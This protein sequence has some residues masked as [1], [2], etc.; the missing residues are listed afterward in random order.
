[1]ETTEIFGAITPLFRD[2]LDIDDLELTPELTARDVDE[3]D[4]L[5]HIRLIVA[6]EQALN[7]KFTTAE[8]STLANVG[9]FVEL[10]GTKL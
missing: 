7:I 10:I 3:W 2:V 8:I 9:E 5:S 1:M 6:V 4:S